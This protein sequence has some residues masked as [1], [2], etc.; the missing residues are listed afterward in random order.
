MVKETTFLSVKYCSLFT[1]T[2]WESPN[3]LEAD[4]VKFMEFVNEHVCQTLMWVKCYMA[5]CWENWN[6]L[7]IVSEYLDLTTLRRCSK[8][9][10]FSHLLVDSNTLTHYF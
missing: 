5:V 7:A 8:C 10:F 3:L 4:Y 9:Y 6:Q 1:L 2:C